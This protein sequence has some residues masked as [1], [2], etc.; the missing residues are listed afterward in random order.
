LGFTG[1]YV[2]VNINSKT[3]I[4]INSWDCFKKVLIRPKNFFFTKFENGYQ[5][6]AEFYADF[7]TVEK[8][9]KNLLTKML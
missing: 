2:A 5:N 6:N 9:A 8:N 4:L 1:I 7:E 3:L